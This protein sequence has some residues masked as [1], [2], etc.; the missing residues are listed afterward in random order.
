MLYYL[1]YLIFGIYTID[2]YKEMGIFC[3]KNLVYV[4]RDRKRITYNMFNIVN[5]CKGYIV[6]SNYI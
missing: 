1:Y 5:R 3:F 6:Y 4:I 2:K